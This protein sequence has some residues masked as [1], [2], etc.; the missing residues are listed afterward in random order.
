MAWQGRLAQRALHLEPVAGKKIVKTK[1][2]SFPAHDG[3]DLLADLYEPQAVANAP[4]MLVRTPYSRRGLLSR[5]IAWDFAERGYNVVIATVRGT[6]GAGGRFDPFLNETE[7]GLATLDWVEKQPWHNGQVVLFGASYLAHVQY[8]LAIEAGDRI[9]AMMPI[10][11]S[12]G[13]R[14]DTYIGGT[15][16]L[17]SFLG[18]LARMH[19]HERF[20]PFVA[21]FLEAK[22]DNR[23]KRATAHLPLSEADKVGTGKQAHWWRPWLDSS[24]RGDP[25]WASE[26]EH[27]DR[28]GEITI[29]TFMVGGW[30]DGLLHG[31]LADY[32]AMRA[33]GRQPYLTIGPWLHVDAAILTEATAEA[34]AWFPAHLGGDTSSLRTQPVRLY[35]QGA[36]EWRE[37]PDYPPPGT[38]EKQWYLGR[39]A[40]LRTGGPDAA[41]SDVFR[42][43]PADPTPA[44]G[45]PTLDA[46]T[47]GRKDNKVLEARTD[48]LTYTGPKLTQPV[49]VIGGVSARISLRSSSEHADVFVRLCD[50]DLTG[51]SINVCDGIQRVTPDLFPADDDGVRIVDVQMWPT[52]YRF[53]PGHRLRV[54]VS[55]GAFPRFPRNHGTGE[56]MATAVR[57][58]AVEHEVLHCSSITLSQL[59]L[60]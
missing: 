54:Q 10:I 59:P 52:A 19:M 43:D 4:T 23:A 44:V 50:V 18:W 14:D 27:R 37:Y 49:E 57:L 3:I 46:R 25:Y 2:L 28:V 9:V 39:D 30:H 6:D 31:M 16:Q 47:G 53:K 48:V 13:F 45:G 51:Q 38:V 26:R 15:F 41:T 24:R 21:D 20:H 29:P 33:A 32:A 22:G 1:D 56:P 34:M 12:S 17:A 35:V 36:E 55:G 40:A 8:A 11:G 5:V 58:V 60:A 7:D 42:Y